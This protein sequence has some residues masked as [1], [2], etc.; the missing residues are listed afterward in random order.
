[1]SV[2]SAEEISAL[3]DMDL[4]LHISMCVNVIGC[5]LHTAKRPC[6]L[7]VGYGR[8]TSSSLMCMTMDPC[9]VGS[10]ERGIKYSIRLSLF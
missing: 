8:L 7:R 4:F 3:S 9:C 6:G 5:C 1:M 10:P 2:V